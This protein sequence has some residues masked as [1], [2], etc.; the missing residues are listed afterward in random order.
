MTRIR[1]DES[2][3]GP[4][5]SSQFVSVS[6]LAFLVRSPGFRICDVR[7][8]R[9]SRDGP[10]RNSPIF[11]QLRF[12]C[13]ALDVPACASRL[14]SA[15]ACEAGSGGGGANLRRR[16]ASARP[17]W[18]SW[19]APQ[20]HPG[21]AERLGGDERG[22]GSASRV[23]VGGRVSGTVAMQIA[24]APSRLPS[25]TRR[26]DARARG[27]V[28]RTSRADTPADRVRDAALRLAALDSAFGRSTPS[29]RRGFLGAGYTEAGPSGGPVAARGVGA[30]GGAVRRSRTEFSRVSS[31]D[32]D[33]R[34]SSSRGR[35]GGDGLGCGS[36]AL[37]ATTL[38]ADQRCVVPD[39]EESRAFVAAGGIVASES[40]DGVPR[41]CA[42]DAER[43]S[44]TFLED[45]EDTLFF[46][47]WRSAG[48]RSKRRPAP[49][50]ASYHARAGHV[51]RGGSA[52]GADDE[53]G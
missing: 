42:G 5:A 43:C 1:L 4:R 36:I 44:R 11:S 31:G 19:S 34:R 28:R 30:V 13:W 27:F 29:A 33:V 16:R 51:A 12:A 49:E 21:V 50:D 45:R 48:R 52:I 41:G 26:A 35:R 3:A 46:H 23:G 25:A 6:R 9:A 32:R 18:R 10:R 40:D 38:N 15:G 14:V 53:T 2:R 22:G 7:R 24:G 8:R 17:R 37:V 39:G 20:G 47:E